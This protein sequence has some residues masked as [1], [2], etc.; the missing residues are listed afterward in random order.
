MSDMRIGGLAS[1]MDIDKLVN[2]LMRAERQPLNKMEQDKTWTEWQ[3]DAYRDVNKQLF[4]LDSMTL[5]MNLS[6]TYQSKEVTS[7]SAAIS[8][9]ASSSAGD[10]NYNVQ[11]T[12]MATAAY[13]LSETRLSKAGEQIDPTA[14]LSSQES[15]FA[16]G[17]DG[18]DF[19]IT[20][21]GEDG[22]T[23]KT[24]SIDME[25]SLNDV[26]DEISNSDLGLRAFYDSS[27]DKVMIERTQTGNYNTDNSK[28]LGAEIGFDSTTAGFLSNTLGIKNGDNSS[29]T[30]K[31]NEKGGQDAT[32]KYNGSLEITTHDNNYTLNGVTFN[33]H[34]VMETAVN[35]N[36]S[37]NIDSAVENITKFV[38]KYNKVIESLNEQVSEKRYRDFPPLTEKQ[39]EDLEEREIELW[40]EKAKSGM[41]RNDSTIQNALFEMRSNWYSTIDTGGEF[42][43]LSQIGIKTSSDYLDGGKLLITEDELREALREDP[44]AVQELFAGNSETGSKGIIDKLEETIA[45]TRQTIERKAGKPTSTEETY[46]LGRR[47]EDMEDRMEAFEDRLV[48]IEDRYW[49]QFGQMEQAIQQLNS[50]SAFLMSNFG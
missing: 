15:K 23:T 34:A 17:F 32:F 41:L 42:T 3:R 39:K 13:N 40:E 28:F 25:Q 36:V 43:Q 5:D 44:R 19:T 16:N 21:Y 45:D 2:D 29:G 27:A 24:F 46:M 38:D 4:E 49:S 33:F 22:P 10:G 6:K 11:V 18:G 9:E 8:A 1:G 20:T 50:Q 26:L 14:S 35:V 7:P 12:Q 48:Q 30:W 37:N 31:L 47:L